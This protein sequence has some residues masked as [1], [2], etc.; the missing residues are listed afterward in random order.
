MPRLITYWSYLIVL[1]KSVHL[2][3]VLLHVNLHH[4][5]DIYVVVTVKQNTFY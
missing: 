5:S 4:H 3:F 2:G 1:H